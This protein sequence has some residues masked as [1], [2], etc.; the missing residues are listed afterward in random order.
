MKKIIFVIVGLLLL[1][2]GL[3]AKDSDQIWNFDKEKTGALP[4]GF[5]NE[6]GDW[7]I[8]VDPTAP[9]KP[10]VMAQQGKNSGSTYNLTLVSGVQ[11]KEVDV[12]V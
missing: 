7:K 1:T 10:N 12:A 11:V 5:T 6:K 3:L 2:T 9:S 8:V 4:Q